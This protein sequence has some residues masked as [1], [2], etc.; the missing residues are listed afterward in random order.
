MGE[1]KTNELDAARAMANA[2]Q[3]AGKPVQFTW[4][5]GVTICAIDLAVHTLG[6]IAN[7]LE[8]AWQQPEPAAEI[9]KSIEHLVKWKA[10]FIAGTQAKVVIASAAD[11]PRV[12]L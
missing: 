10:R 4:Q 8:N 5:Q 6:G 7:Q 2:R 3:L 11:I 9:Q 1:A 12:R